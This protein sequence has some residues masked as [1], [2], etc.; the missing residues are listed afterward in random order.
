MRSWALHERSSVLTRA[1]DEAEF[2]AQRR[3]VYRRLRQ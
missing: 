2:H 3:K 1:C